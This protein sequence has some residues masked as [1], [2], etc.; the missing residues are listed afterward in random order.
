M[1]HRPLVHT[2]GGTSP[3]RGLDTD[4]CHYTEVEN[5]DIEQNQT[6]H[7]SFPCLDWFGLDLCGLDH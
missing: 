2:G 6:F 5:S 4:P 7:T 3:A 1:M